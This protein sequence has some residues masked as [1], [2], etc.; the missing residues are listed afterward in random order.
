MTRKSDVGKLRLPHAVYDD[1]APVLRVLG[2]ANRLR[3]VDLLM[4]NRH[5][6]GEL[7]VTLGLAPNAVSQHL[8][9]MRAH[10]IVRRRRRGREVL[11]SVVHP[12]AKSLLQCMWKTSAGEAE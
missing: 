11:Y 9:I 6:V 5:R 3:I 10:G 1:I 4:R 12:A 7:A 8:G 2:H